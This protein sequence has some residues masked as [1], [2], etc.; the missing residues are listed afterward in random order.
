MVFEDDAVVDI[1]EAATCGDE[2]APRSA[3]LPKVVNN[4]PGLNS[5]ILKEPKEYEAIKGTLDDFGKCFTVKFGILAL[6]SA[7]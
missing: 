3:P 5:F 1:V 4:S 6:K 7:G 2:V